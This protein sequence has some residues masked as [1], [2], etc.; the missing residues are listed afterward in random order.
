MLSIS[1]VFFSF[2]SIF[3]LY[4]F[5]LNKYFSNTYFECL[6]PAHIQLGEIT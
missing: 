6:A 4:L 3:T 1:I 2:Q 5:Q